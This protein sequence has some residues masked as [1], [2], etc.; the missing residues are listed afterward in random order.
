VETYGRKGQT[1][2]TAGRTRLI[3]EAM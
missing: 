1:V 2:A 3:D